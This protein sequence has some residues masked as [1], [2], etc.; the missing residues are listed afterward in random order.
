M[1]NTT[2]LRFAFYDAFS[3]VAFGGSQAAIVSDASAVGAAQRVQ[4]AKELGLPA[5]AF[6]D[7]VTDHVVRAQFYSTVMALPMCGHGT[8]CLMT[9]LV[10]TGELTCADTG[11][12]V[13]DL[14]LPGGSAVVELERTDDGRLLVLLDVK[15]PTIES[16]PVDRP[17]LARLL[18]IS[19][20]DFDSKLPIEVASGDF[21]HLVVPIATLNGM[22]RMEPDFAG[23]IDFCHAHKIETVATF[24]RQVERPESV[25]H[26]RDFCPAVGVW[27]SASAGT[28]NGALSS[29]LVRHRVVC[30][31]DTDAVE[32][33]AEQG[34][35]I[36]RPSQ[37]RSLI[38]LEGDR[39]TRLQVGG[40]ATKI[41]DGVISLPDNA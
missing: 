36:G 12:T 2:E 38:K 35:E 21:I 11:V 31:D 32:V 29:Y 39:I 16:R 26:V 7:E 8:I 3:D 18:G 37:I 24:S 9:G 25:I 41:L 17:H 1:Q 30:A 5:T 13:V 34:L 20:E 22:K 27:E 10:E 28:T 14:Q 23:I 40:V 4:V 19:A 6:V 33:I 15:Q